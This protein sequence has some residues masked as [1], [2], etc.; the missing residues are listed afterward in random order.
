MQRTAS[1]DKTSEEFPLS[2]KFQI[3]QLNFLVGDIEGNAQKIIDTAESAIGKADIIVFPELALTG[4]PPEDLLLRDHFIR[5]VE[6]A[7]ALI[8]ARV[9]GIHLVV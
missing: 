2:L 8:V 9:N 5:R 3:A 7:I 4:Y 1:Q 6:R